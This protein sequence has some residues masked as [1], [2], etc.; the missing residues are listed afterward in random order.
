MVITFVA[1]ARIII[2]LSAAVATAGQRDMFH[3][4]GAAA[5][6]AGPSASPAAATAETARSS[7]AA[8][9]ALV[10][11]LVAELPQSVQVRARLPRL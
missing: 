3:S 8:R 9:P 4:P 2:F 7:M 5:L 6:S 11:A 1:A 10:R